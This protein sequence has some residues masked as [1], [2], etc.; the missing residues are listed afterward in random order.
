MI[1]GKRRADV[2]MNYQ[3][4]L[5]PETRRAARGERRLWRGG[6]GTA[7]AQRLVYRAATETPS[8]REG[9]SSILSHCPMCVC[10][11][12]TIYRQQR[13]QTQRLRI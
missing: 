9:G 8:V 4:T 13:T 2:S 10:H 11:Q 7:S 3:N 6:E 12:E 1:Q 5:G